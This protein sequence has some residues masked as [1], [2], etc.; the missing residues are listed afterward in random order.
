M[1]QHPPR[2]ARR[3]G[4]PQRPVSSARR[5][6]AHCVGT[7][8]E[9]LHPDKRRRDEIVSDHEDRPA[10][11]L[12]DLMPQGQSV[13]RGAQHLALVRAVPQRRRPGN[14]VPKTVA[15]LW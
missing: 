13:R 6:L 1:A 8:A 3:Q 4:R 5:T 15:R 10:D 11:A 7:N 14:S 2:P 9:S 12:Q